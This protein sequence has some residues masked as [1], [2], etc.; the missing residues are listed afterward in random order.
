MAQT[1]F[2]KMVA[3]QVYKPD[4]HCSSSYRAALELCLDYERLYLAN[5]PGHRQLLHSI[6]GSVGQNVEIRPSIRVDYGI[7]T[8]IGSDCFF[9]FNTIILDVA[10]V[11]LGQAVLV[12]SN[13]QFLTPTHPLNPLDRRQGWEG[14]LAISVADNVWIGSGALIL[15]G[16]SIGENS[17]IG[18]GSVVSSDIPANS[19]AVGNPAR[20]CKTLNKGQRPASG[21][22][23]AAALGISS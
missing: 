21:Q 23:S 22:F 15:P 7:N 1:T 2:E 8:H 11:T 17:V 16:V 18:A 14:G 19:V 6:F 5:D 10:P 13:V 4:A 9:N 3:G 12:G 20:V